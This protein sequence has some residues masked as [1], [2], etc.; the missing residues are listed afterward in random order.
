ML[1]LR[2]TLL[3]LLI[4]ASGWLVSGENMIT[5]YGNVQHL[6]CDTGLIKVRSTTYG[7]TNR[8]TCNARPASEIA[9][10]NCALK[11]S[12]IADRCNGL[13][14]CEVKTDLLG[15]PDPCFGTYKYYNTTYDCISGQNIVICEQGYST[16]NCGDG[17]I[18]IINANYGRANAV[19]CVNG[20]PSS[21][22]QNT[23]CYAPSTFSKVASMCN[24]KTTCTVDASYTIFTDPCVGTA[25][26]LSVSYICHRSIVTCEGN[27]AILTC[28]DRRI[29]AV[30]A[31]YGRTDSTTCSSGR[32]ANQ[33]SN[34]N[35]Y[36]PD[37]LNKVAARCNGQSSC[38][39]P[40]TND[41]FSDP[42][43]GT[44]KYLTVVYYCS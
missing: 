10:T 27:T 2:L 22:L 4:A 25:K 33:I 21:V 24:G 11:I 8:D 29:N 12:T 13:R 28:G 19:T 39:V 34:T 41:L 6:A 17:Y 3:T 16:L 43:Y 44:Y 15:N 7:R 36:T 40:A 30:S 5:C 9:N 35:C 1:S 20:L 26:Y 14:E 38:S 37:A 42:C 18:Q 23:N 32:P 31:N